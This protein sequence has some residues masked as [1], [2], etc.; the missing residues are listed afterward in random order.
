MKIILIVLDSVG[1]GALPDAAKYNDAG[2]NTLG[3]IAENTE[4]FDLP[5]LAQLGLYHLLPDT[6]LRLPASLLG[7][8]GKM[9][10]ASNGKDTPIGHWEITGL[11][12]E[13]PLPTYPDGFPKDLIE[14]YETKIGTKTIGNYAS[15][16]TEIIKAL[17]AEHC[18]TGYP[19]VY[20]SAD[21]VFQ[22]AAHEDEKIF[23]LKRLY[24]I[25]EIARRMLVYPHNIGRVIARPFIGTDGSFKRTS[26]RHDYAIDP[27]AP[28]LL[29]KLQDAGYEVF[30]VGKIKD[31][32]NGSG[33]TDSVRT[34]NNKDGMEKTLEQIKKES[35]GSCQ[36]HR[37][38]FTNLVDYDMLWGHRRD[39][40]AYY[41]G[42]KEFD[43]F[44]PRIMEDMSNEDI[45]FITA[46][47]GCD[48]S[49]MSH[50]DHT[51]EYVPVFVFGKKL[52]KGVDLG[53]RK[54]FADLG[55]TIADIFGIEKL[56]SGTSFKNEI[57]L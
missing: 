15:S 57:M 28:T 39:I 54:T 41:K 29:N 50:T 26:N 10:E 27:A 7:N 40:P 36:Q 34:I 9:A 31:I 2:A 21:S 42:L 17:G 5:N 24:E 45:L 37:L 3:H 8:Y 43:D 44:L 46:D 16:G 19:I 1:I 48:P 12:T 53:I 22:I 32:F 20:T 30:G 49:Y 4:N 6:G 33:I 14:E 38:I 55:Q 11:I 23:G 25:C 13:K 52:K 35:S 51:R 18:Q 47:H 56:S